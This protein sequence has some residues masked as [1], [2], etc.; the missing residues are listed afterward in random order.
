MSFK[1]LPSA[2]IR[3]IERSVFAEFATVSGAG[4]P[5]DTPMLL[6]PD[7]GL[8]HFATATGIS[9][10]VKAARARN[11]PRT[12]LLIEGLPGEPVVLVRAMAAVRDADLQANALRYLAETG[13]DN[14]AHDTEWAEG[15]TAVWYWAR[16]IIECYP[17]AS[18][19][20]MTRVP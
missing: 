15:R 17:N 13:F 8:T 12:G 5:I 9:Y 6:F 3:V 10:P 4:V 16:L 19:G 20:G 7:E 1:D 11:N 2:V 14:F 18:G